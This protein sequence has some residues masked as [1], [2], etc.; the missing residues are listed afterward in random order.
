MIEKIKE[1]VEKEITE[2]K[3]YQLEQVHMANTPA[4]YGEV[5][6]NG[7]ENAEDASFY[8]KF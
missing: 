5:S 8:A 3:K 6:P 2:L 7:H 4:V 1:A